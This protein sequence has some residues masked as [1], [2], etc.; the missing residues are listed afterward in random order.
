MKEL[1]FTQQIKDQLLAQQGN[2]ELITEEAWAAEKNKGKKLNSHLELLEG[3][4][5]FLFM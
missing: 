5:S 2:E 1:D 3:L 4:K